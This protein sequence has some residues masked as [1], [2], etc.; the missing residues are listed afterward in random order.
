M[1]SRDWV[2]ELDPP[3]DTELW[4]CAFEQGPVC[5]TGAPFREGIPPLEVGPTNPIFE[6][7]IESPLSTDYWYRAFEHR[8]TLL[9]GLVMSD[10]VSVSNGMCPLGE[11]SQSKELKFQSECG[12]LFSTSSGGHCVKFDRAGWSA[13]AGPRGDQTLD[14]GKENP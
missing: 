13:P 9:P 7:V 12:G 1:H 4:D 14:R 6:H 2:F 3:V 11:A 10:R 5:R 8:D